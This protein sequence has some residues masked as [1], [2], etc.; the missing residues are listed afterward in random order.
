MQLSRKGRPIALLVIGALMATLVGIQLVSPPQLFAA[1]TRYVGHGGGPGICADPTYSA[2]QDAVDAARPGDTIHVCAGVYLLTATITLYVDGLTFVGD[3][4]TATIIDGSNDGAP[5]GLFDAST[6]GV[7]ATTFEELTLQNGEAIHGGAIHAPAGAVTVNSCIFND[8]SASDWGGAIDAHSLF[9][10]NGTF[11]GN[12][13]GGDGGGGFEAGPGPVVVTTS[14]FSGNSASTGGGGALV[15]ISDLVTVTN[16]TF[17][18]NSAE[19]GGAVMDALG[20]VIVSGS[21]F[22]GNNATLDGGAILADNV[23][24]TESTFSGNSASSGTAILAAFGPISVTNSTFTGNNGGDAAIEGFVGVTI[25]NSTFSDNSSDGGEVQTLESVTVTNTI[26]ARA[27]AT[28]TCSSMTTIA[29]GGGNFSTDASCG[30][31][32][33][34]S[35]ETV[36]LASLN[37]G[38]LTDNGGPTQTIALGFGSV[39]IDAASCGTATDQRGA[40]R[41]ATLCDSGAYEAGVPA[42]PSAPS[43]V[44]ATAGN[45]SALVAWDPPASD[46]GSPIS[47]Y[48]VTSAPDAKTC[49]TAAT[50][51]TVSGLSNGTAYTFRVTAENTVGSGPAST[52]SAPVTP[53]TVP[54]SPSAVVAT[55][56]NASALV[57]WDPPA[58]DGGSPISAYTV[59]SAPDAKTCTT[60]A[61]S[62]TVSGLSNGTAYTF[63]V[64]AENTVGSGPASTASA[65]VTPSTVPGS[66]S[67]VVATAGNA[68]AL[69]A[70]DPP[71]SDGGSPISAYTVTSA[72]DA[73]TCT[74]AATSCTVSGLSN[75]T[76]YT[77]RVTAENTVG[78]GPASTASAP[79]TPS[80]VPGSPSAVVATA[81]NA[82]ALVAWDPPASDGGSPISAYTV[83]SAPDAKTCTTAATSCT[84]SGLSNGTAYTFRVTAENTVGSGPAST[85]SAPVTPGTPFTDIASSI[86]EGD[87]VWLYQSGITAG[88]SS[89][90]FCPDEVVTRGQMAAFLDRALHLPKTTTDYFTDDSG[91]IFEMNINRLAASEITTGCSPTTFCPDDAVTRGQMAAFLDRALALPK[92]TTDFFTDDSGSIFE[93]SIN[94]LA[95]SGIT[96]GCSATTFCPDDVVTRGQMAAFL[97]RALK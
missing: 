67:A 75:G 6:S 26:F 74:T 34:T 14:T 12:S 11:S 21:T 22:G 70:W 89:T 27:S 46:G 53:S 85:A 10:T 24:V 37:L 31:T 57:A 39:A 84:V 38:A 19:N 56:G 7:L 72:P 36:D 49:T 3:S 81:G 77:F 64:T 16:S 52:A 61:T 47:A 76:A 78:S 30:F 13:G 40:A 88:C 71:A 68:S 25:T 66:P 90:I 15:S 28:D 83:T 82:S 63:R 60:A 94:R 80:T 59:T 1:T 95:S 17:V 43:A 5:V 92:T 42:I 8:N 9:V 4:A 55:A 23:V 93:K 86:F 91:T 33:A 29:D 51:C 2:I 62:C 44:V 48:T 32:D 18:G 41:P 58:S 50:S 45:A 35:H 87:I 73:K 96:T 79:V 65:P 20:E 54:G 97:H 69:V